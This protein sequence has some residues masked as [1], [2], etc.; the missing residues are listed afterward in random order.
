[1]RANIINIETDVKYLVESLDDC[2]DEV[3]KSL[4]S[5]MLR[6]L[7]ESKFENVI[8]GKMVMELDWNSVQPNEE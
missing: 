3:D 1:M 4:Y 8:V 6:G 5:E 2:K 7:S